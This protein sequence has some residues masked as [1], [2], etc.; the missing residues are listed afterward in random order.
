[1]EVKRTGS[2][3]SHFNLGIGNAEWGTKYNDTFNVFKEPAAPKANAQ[4][5]SRKRS[6][7]FGLGKMGNAYLTNF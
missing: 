7:G 1:M 3:A 6:G 5:G 2:N 4:H